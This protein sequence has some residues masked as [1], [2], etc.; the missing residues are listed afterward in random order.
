MSTHEDAVEAAASALVIVTVVSIIFYG[1]HSIN[2]SDKR[3]RQ[4]EAEEKKQQREF[5]LKK[6]QLKQG[7]ICG[8]YLKSTEM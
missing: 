3:S 8:G 2:K 5:E 4:F 6:L 7:C 1:I